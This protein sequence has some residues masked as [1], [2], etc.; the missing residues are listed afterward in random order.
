MPYVQFA[1]PVGV[2]TY[3]AEHGYI[4]VLVHARGLGNSGGEVQFLSPREGRDGKAI[5]DWAAHRLEGSDGRVGLVGC[6]WPGAI[7]LTDAAHIGRGSPLK[8]VVA[9]C[10]G[11]DNMHRQSW[12]NAGLPTMSFWQFEARGPGLVGN[13]AAARR[14]FQAFSESVLAGGDMACDR[15]FWRQRGRAT[16]A[17]QIVANGVPVLLWSGWSDVVETG[18]R[19]A[20]SRCRTQPRSGRCMPRWRASSARR[21]AAS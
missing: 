11:L 18:A 16:L 5:V 12:L 1:V 7:A 17:Q 10:S 21:R 15:D 19:H 9:A 8:A 2:N 13:T 14:F 6:S 4:S 20:Y 3:F